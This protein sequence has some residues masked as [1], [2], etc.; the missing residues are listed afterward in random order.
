MNKIKFLILLT[1]FIDV[2]GM[3]IV[4][5][6]LPF[7]LERFTSSA[8]VITSLFAV[9]SLFS[10]LSAPIIG[11]LSDRVGR[12]PMLIA[13]IFSTSF[14]W[15]IFSFAPNLLI[16]FL[17]RIIDGIAA[18]NLPIA[19]AYLTD[20]SKDQKERST[21]LGL[22]GAVFGIA[23][24]LGPSLGGLLS[25]VS[26][27]FPFLFVGI[28]AFLNATLAIFFL[29][30]THKDRNVEK[31]LSLNPISPI[32]SA[33]K[34]EKLRL[35]YLAWFLFGL[36]ITSFQSVFALYT[37][38]V[39]GFKEVTLGFM[40]AGMG[41]II[42]LNQVVALKHFWLKYFKEPALEL[43]MLALYA[44]GLWL[45]GIGNIYV[46]IFSM[47]LMTFGQS[48]LRVVMNSQILSS[49]APQMRG[50]VLGITS[51]VTSLSM[52]LAPAF[53]GYLFGINMRAPFIVA[54]IFLLLALFVLLK[55]RKELSKLALSEEVEIISEI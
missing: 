51:S 8:V 17:G 26:S 27:S 49:A 21:N 24:I 4:I 34:D 30:E 19:Q 33:V 12:R 10:F 43:G 35:N 52:T 48:V 22:I 42:A 2:I 32:I 15:L 38:A 18:G 9:Y 47:I 28:L 5:P 37:G 11:A 29:P 25:T 23:F 41:I 39:F 44:V 54:G 6:I 31:K 20:I 46:F 36:A 13:S 50:E 7:Y 55:K 45:A 14:G 1:V 3:G 53:A 40:F 16:L